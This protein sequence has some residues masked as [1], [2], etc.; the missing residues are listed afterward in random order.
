[1]GTTTV[2]IPALLDR[3]SRC[4]VRCHLC[5]Q[6]TSL[7]ERHWHHWPGCLLAWDF[8]FIEQIALNLMHSTVN[9]KMCA[10]LLTLCSF[11]F[12]PK[13]IEVLCFLSV[14]SLAPPLP[15]LF[16]QITASSPYPNVWIFFSFV[17]SCFLFSDL[18][19]EVQLP[20]FT[21]SLGMTWHMSI[22]LLN[23]NKK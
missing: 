18:D 1:M 2:R 7:C 15:L 19:I 8:C 5:I 16:Y 20:K 10:L 11:V 21:C 23:A 4:I 9:Q 6:H 14:C 17:S 3:L 12:A 22:L 13:D